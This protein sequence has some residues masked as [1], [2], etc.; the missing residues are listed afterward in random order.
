MFDI[1]NPDTYSEVTGDEFIYLNDEPLYNVAEKR[2][3]KVKEVI[4]LLQSTEDFFK[5]KDPDFKFSK[6]GINNFLKN[7]YKKFAPSQIRQSINEQ[8]K[9]I[10]KITKNNKF[11]PKDETTFQFA[12]PDVITVIDK[13]PIYDIVYKNG[14]E[15]RNYL[16]ETNYVAELEQSYE[17]EK[18]FLANPDKKKFV[19]N[20]AKTYLMRCIDLSIKKSD[21]TIKGYNFSIAQKEMMKYLTDEDKVI[22]TDVIL[23]HFKNKH[24]RY[25]LAQSIFYAKFS[26]GIDNMLFAELC[27][28]KNIEKEQEIM[29]DYYSGFDT[30]ESKKELNDVLNNEYLNLYPKLKKRIKDNLIELLGL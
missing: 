11:N 13:T 26:G 3:I 29:E 15:C 28:C 20:F 30:I 16:F 4:S 27:F 9:D 17:F 18:D 2:Y 6:E 22:L 5:T 23:E 10:S 8:L 19:G 21:L 24:K 14:V 25:Q 12:K 7:L 1:Y